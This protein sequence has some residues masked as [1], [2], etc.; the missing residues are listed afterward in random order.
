MEAITEHVANSVRNSSAMDRNGSMFLCLII[1]TGYC[2]LTPGFVQ[3]YG[4]LYQGTDLVENKIF[5]T[6]FQFYKFTNPPW[7]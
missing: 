3:S 6:S 4:E 1:P 5:F 7:Q 2:I